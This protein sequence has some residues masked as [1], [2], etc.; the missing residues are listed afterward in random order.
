[1]LL[2]ADG[3]ERAHAH[4]HFA[5]AGDHQHAALRL[6]ERKPEADHRRLAHSAPQREVERRIPCRGDVPGGRAQ[7]GDDQ[8]VLPAGK[9]LFDYVTPLHREVWSWKLLIPITRCGISTATEA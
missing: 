1:R 2:Y 7:A 8:K 6:R 4:Q 5:V 9:K 3:G